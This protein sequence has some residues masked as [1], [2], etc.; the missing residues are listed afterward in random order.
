M[1][2]QKVI[3]EISKLTNDEL[4]ALEEASEWHAVPFG[5]MQVD[6]YAGDAIIREASALYWQP[7]YQDTRRG[8]DGSVSPDDLALYEIMFNAVPAGLA[9]HDDYSFPVSAKI[10]LSYPLQ[11]VWEVTV[12]IH[13]NRLGELFCIAHDMYEH[14]YG[15]DDKDWQAEGHQDS[16][17]R[18]GGVVLNRA[19]G[20]HVW[21]HDMSDLVFEALLFTPNPEWPKEER[22]VPVIIEVKSV[23]DLVAP[24]DMDVS[25]ATVTSFEALHLEK[26]ADSAPFIGTFMFAIGS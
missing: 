14:I 26:H 11:E 24:P 21:G 22:K 10:V 5:A 9:G 13:A 3:P 23:K 17:P 7:N 15:L 16:A 4:V 1:T 18:L 2:I 20:K 19:A 12:Q 6:A 8:R 25:P